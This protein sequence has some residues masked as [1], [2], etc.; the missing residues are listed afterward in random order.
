LTFE[1]KYEKQK[2]KCQIIFEKFCSPKERKCGRP[3]CISY[4]S[5]GSFIYDGNMEKIIKM[6][7]EKENRISVYTNG[8]DAVEQ[9]MYVI[10]KKMATG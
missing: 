4:G 7:Q 2:E 1:E 9:Y 8:D 5:E 10:L 3:N 6:E